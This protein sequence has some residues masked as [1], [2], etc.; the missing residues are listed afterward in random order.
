MAYY[1]KIGVRP[2]TEICTEEIFCRV[3]VEKELRTCNG[4]GVQ[5]H[6]FSIV[7]I[8]PVR[9]GGRRLHLGKVNRLLWLNQKGLYKRMNLKSN[10]N[11][12]T[13]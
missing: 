2:R 13:D 6:Q 1:C 4:T 10:G 7:S 11:T 3:S 8:L 9:L 12:H 5:V